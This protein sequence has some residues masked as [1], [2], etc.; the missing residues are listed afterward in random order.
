MEDA[1]YA[2]VEIT[3]VD[4]KAVATGKGISDFWVKAMT[5]HTIGATITEKDRPIL[6]YLTD[7][8]LDLHPQYIGDG[9][10]LT[11]TFAPNTYF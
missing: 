6:G 11:F 2:K 5:N 4:T 1:D 9:Y 3:P 10:T 7:I 8:K